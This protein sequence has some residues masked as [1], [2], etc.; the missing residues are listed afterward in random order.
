MPAVA[1]LVVSDVVIAEA[2][3]HDRPHPLPTVAPLNAVTCG[4]RVRRTRRLITRGLHLVYTCGHGER[5][6]E[7]DALLHLVYT[8]FTV[9]SHLVYTWFT[10]AAAANGLASETPFYTWFTPGLHLVYTLFTP[11]AAANGLGSE[12]SRVS[13]A[14]L[15]TRA[16]R[17]VEG[18]PGLHLVYTWFAPGS[19]LSAT[20]RIEGRRNPTQIRGLRP[21]DSAG[22]K[23]RCLHQR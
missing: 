2:R 21:D 1:D 17:R 10:P 19:H 16:T 20:R 11:A 23:S 5:A 13:H 12:N 3:K 14:G 8:W 15:Q 9:T 6:R 22:I 4:H 7:R 18:A